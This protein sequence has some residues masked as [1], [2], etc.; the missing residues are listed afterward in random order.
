MAPPPIKVQVV[1]SY[2]DK[3]IR[4]AQNDLDKLRDQALALQTGMGL[5]TI[6]MQ[7]NGE[8]LATMG[9]KLSLG[10]TLPI[11]GIG[12][13]ASKMAIDFDSA[14]TKI[15]SLVGISSDE[16]AGM[17]QSVLKLSSTT[18][19][20]ATE[21]A[22]ALFV[23]TSAGLRGS[24]AMSALDASAKAGAAG[25]GA[26]ADIARSVAGA[27]NAY[28]PAML[29]A[30]RATD[31]IVATARAGNFETSQFAAALGRV[32]PFA[33]QAGASLEQ[34][35]GAVALLTRT[36]GDAAQSVTQ[37]AALMRAF[38]VPTEEAKKA[39][40]AAG[41]SASDMR[42]RIGRDGLAAALTFLDGKLGGN[43]EQLGKLLGSSEAAGAAFQ[44]LDADSKTLAETFG[45]VTNSVGMTEDA[46]ATTAETAGFKTQQAFIGLQ[47]SLIGVGDVILPI[48]A[49]MA[50]KVSTLANA[51]TALPA[52]LKSVVVAFGSLLAA[53]GPVLFIA[54][55]LMTAYVSA[56]VAMS[57]AMLRLK[58]TFTTAF[59]SMSA[60][61][62]ASVIQIK[63]AMIAAQTQMGAM[64]AGAR[65]AGFIAIG[66]FKA[67]GVAVKGLLISLGPVGIGLAAV[68]A[69]YAIMAGRADDTKANVESLTEALRQQGEQ[70]RQTA[71][72]LIAEDLFDKQRETLSK[73]GISFEEAVAAVTGGEQAVES[74]RQK[75][76]ETDGATFSYANS[77]PVLTSEADLLATTIDNL[78]KDFV[79]ASTEA[80]GLEAATNAVS[81]SVDGLGLDATG[82]ASDLGTLQ[83]E[84]KKLS[85]LFLGFDK[86]VAA[87]RAKDAF[88]GFLRDI[89][90]E[91]DKNNRALLGNGKAAQDNRNTILDALEKAKADA[92]AFGEANNLTLAQVEARFQKNAENVR[93]TL[94]DE[95]FKKK[96]LEKFF[97]SEFVNVAGVSVQGEM[98]IAIGTMADRLG[99]IAL[100]EFK[101][102]GLDL[103]NGLAL[104]VAASSP[105][106][107]IET[108][109]AI[110]NAEAAARAAAE[111]KSP[112]KVFERIGN[113]L[114]A[115]LEKGVK[116][117]SD[118]VAERAKAAIDK[119]IGAVR[120]S[121]D[122]FTGFKESV[123]SSIVGLLD[124]GGAYESYTKRQDA[125]T[126]TLAEL[127]KFQAEVQGE[128]TDEQK[129]KLLELQGA[130]QDAQTAAANGAQSIV[131]EFVNQGKKLSEF[132]ANMNLLLSKGLSRQAFETIIAAGADRGANIADALAQGNIDANIANVNA[133]FT[134]VAAMGQQVG[135]QASGNFMMQG[136]VLAQSMLVGLIK[137]FMPSG[138]KRRELLAAINGMVSEAVGAMAPIANVRMPGANA[139][140]FAAAAIENPFGLTVPAPMT[141]SP[142]PAFRFEN[143]F[144]L[145]IPAMAAG[146]IVT[147]PTL[148]LIGE[149]GP[150]AIIPL[151][152]AGGM[153]TTINLT[154]NAGMGADGVQVGEQI[155]SALRQYQRR[156]GALPIK[157]A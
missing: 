37:I 120:N 26:T 4:R 95:G 96:D 62:N 83:T 21:L 130:Y 56:S 51:F 88:R 54:G 39:L 122:A 113:D 92:V 84:T 41:L 12:V 111:S 5:S 128:T 70:G 63:V 102:V 154:V 79:S 46:F 74:F 69:V 148:G 48:I 94:V 59:A 55:K 97:G 67:I 157:V 28:G 72:K 29:D 86:D 15:V 50:E 68:S 73:F 36:N 6:A 117:K 7:K 133:V 40:A 25:L 104:G 141:G 87:I 60:S 30:G 14:M 109:R 118:K 107:D 144:G 99:P 65:A 27:L 132:T 34:V 100:R 101:G 35:G 138:K 131:E 89:Q 106:I 52:P 149:A 145:T 66:S 44:I 110:T 85:D 146:G 20:S 31:I 75:L 38:V 17:R 42:D 152:R 121:V 134:S 155:V 98:A 77:I 137:E 143:P 116:D 16:V 140:T 9:K 24:E 150:E 82:A 49:G 135:N 115:G 22:D 125:V 76:M 103:G 45:V 142:A 139:P 1:G 71:L 127:L 43:R 11:V 13:A 93:K 19:K 61:A 80:A 129:V 91:L 136:V 33:K 90:D 2:N 114:M 58:T 153:G 105:K 10:L 3:D 126:T 64:A 32:L 23:V 8:A 18:G 147:G 112:S 123:Q 81:T 119:A 124:L 78:S 53:I 151:N 47:N 108:R 57:A 156:N